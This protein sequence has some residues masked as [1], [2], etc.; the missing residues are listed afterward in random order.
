MCM[1]QGYR[2]SGLL[3]LSGTGLGLFIENAWD[4]GFFR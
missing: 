4:L 1:A 3:K 2:F